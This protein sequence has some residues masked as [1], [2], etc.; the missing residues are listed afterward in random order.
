VSRLQEL[1]ARLKSEGKTIYGYGASAKG[2]TLLNV[3]GI[4]ADI[5]DCI[6]DTTPYKIGKFSPGMRIPVVAPG[7]RPEPDYYLLLVWNYLPGVLA[8]EEAF[9]AGGGHFIVPIPVPAVI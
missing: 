2:N 6:V 5:L 1:L 8:R 3:A 4:G 7:E 9:R